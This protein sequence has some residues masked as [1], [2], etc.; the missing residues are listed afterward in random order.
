[1]N[2]GLPHGHAHQVDGD[3][4]SIGAMELGH[5]F[6][7]DRVGRIERPSQSVC[8]PGR[9]QEPL[10]WMVPFHID[11]QLGD[12]TEGITPI[13]GIKHHRQGFSP[14]PQP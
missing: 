3:S 4:C 6:L 13:R 7:L 12:V 1:M 9:Q 8:D 5:G 14:A 2:I 11:I 10:R